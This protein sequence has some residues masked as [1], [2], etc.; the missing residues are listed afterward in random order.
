VLLRV[1]DSYWKDHLRNMDHLREGIG[2]RA[3]GQRDPF[4]EYQL[5]AFDMFQDM[6][7]HIREDTIR[8]ISSTSGLPKLKSPHPG[9]PHLNLLGKKWRQHGVKIRWEEMTP[10]LA[11]VV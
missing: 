8:Y 2:L 3:I 4:V 5:E 6:I 11:E 10:V 7:A 1:V 9:L